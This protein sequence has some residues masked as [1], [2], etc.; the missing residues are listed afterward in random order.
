MS[1][2]KDD[3]GARKAVTD[4]SPFACS[5]G[6]DQLGDNRSGKLPSAPGKRSD[7]VCLIEVHD[8]SLARLWV[9]GVLSLNRP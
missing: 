2:I 5:Q 3:P 9:T 7:L 8:G 4:R 1:A 6:K